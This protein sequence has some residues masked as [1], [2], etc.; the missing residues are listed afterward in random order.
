[1]GLAQRILAKCCQLDTPVSEVQFDLSGSGKKIFAL[2]GLAGKS[3]WLQC[4]RLSVAGLDEEDTFLFAGLQDDGTALESEQC[5]RLF[6]LS[7][8]ASERLLLQGGWSESR[9]RIG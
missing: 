9:N 1:V 4:T 2:A 5:R 8:Q 3:G 6:D 7:G